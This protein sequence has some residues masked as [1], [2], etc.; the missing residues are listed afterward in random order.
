MTI[1]KYHT[2]SATSHILHPMHLIISESYT[3]TQTGQNKSNTYEVKQENKNIIFSFN[4]DRKEISGQAAFG[5]MVIM[6]DEDG[7]SLYIRNKTKLYKHYF[8]LY[9]T[10]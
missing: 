2:P 6:Q 3:D 1:T 7:I 10:L 8:R 5:T 9:F 4:G